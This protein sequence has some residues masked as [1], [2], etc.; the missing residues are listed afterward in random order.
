MSSCSAVAIVEGV[1]LISVHAQAILND[2]LSAHKVIKTR[3]IELYQLWIK[4][5]FFF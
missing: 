2:C 5:G 1:D 4:E 3:S